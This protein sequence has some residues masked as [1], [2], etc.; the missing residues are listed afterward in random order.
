MYE[1]RQAA[2]CD[3]QLHVSQQPPLPSWVR[4]IIA[5]NILATR[6][7]QTGYMP[8]LAT[9]VVIAEHHRIKG[10]RSHLPV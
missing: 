8:V 5:V 3:T 4:N 7:G 10:E 1:H 6:M 9:A 2:A